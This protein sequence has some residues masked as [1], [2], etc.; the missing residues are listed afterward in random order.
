MPKEVISEEHRNFMTDAES[1]TWFNKDS[2]NKCIHS[3][4]GWPQGKF[5]GF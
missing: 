5:A 2:L 4:W 3:I 1:S